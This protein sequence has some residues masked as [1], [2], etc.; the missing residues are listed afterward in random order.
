MND[1]F[2]TDYS[3]PGNF[4]VLAGILFFIIFIRYIVFSGLFHYGLRRFFK[5]REM[6]HLDELGNRTLREMGWSV[7]TSLIFACIGMGLIILW[8]QGGT[9]LYLNLSDFPLWYLPVS[10]LIYLVLHETY[11]YWVHRWMHLPKVFPL[12]HR[13]HHASHETNAHTSFSFHPLESLLQAIIIPVLLLVIPLHTSML[14]VLLVIM[15][16][17]GT[18]NHLGYEIFP[19]GWARHPLGR[20]IIGAAHHDRHHKRFRYNYG[21]YFT[22]WDRWM[23][24]EDPEFDDYFE[25]ITRR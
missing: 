18:I 16:L 4:L 24:T 3:Q 13:V 17:S 14:L 12:V 25:E 7:L 1:F 6:H 20:W 21:L 5:G 19:S 10:L 8:Q 15:T 11:Y 23:G 2:A 22:F 9:A